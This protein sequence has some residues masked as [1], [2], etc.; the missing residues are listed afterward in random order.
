MTQRFRHLLSVREHWEDEIYASWVSM[1]D[2]STGS[3]VAGDIPT[4]D[5]DVG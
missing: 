5:F 4:D 2:A 3:T 1:T